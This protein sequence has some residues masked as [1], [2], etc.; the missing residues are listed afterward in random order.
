[1]KCPFCAN[2]DLKVVDSRPT[3]DGKSIRRRR[4]CTKCGERFT[5]YETIENLPIMVI[6]KDK[7]MEIYDRQKVLKGMLLACANRPV[8]MEKLEGVADEVEAVI[9][10]SMEKQVTSEYIGE[11]IILRLRLIDEVSYVRFASVYRQFTDIKS[12][13]KELE[14]MLEDD[15]PPDRSRRRRPPSH[16]PKS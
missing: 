16:L 12:F 9:K 11:Q 5:T 15:S 7:T 8:S 10:N 13:M 14:K 4:E 2:D 3:A 1:M 6:K